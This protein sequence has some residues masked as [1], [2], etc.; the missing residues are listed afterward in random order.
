MKG[1][2]TKRREDDLGQ[3]WPEVGSCHREAEALV[4]C[5]Y[6]GG[7]MHACISLGTVK[8]LTGEITDWG[9]GAC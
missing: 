1:K 8:V 7:S 5:I 2:E 9:V 3:C 4:W 6:L